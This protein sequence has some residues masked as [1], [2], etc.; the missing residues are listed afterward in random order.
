MRIKL[1]QLFYL[2][3]NERNIA[4]LFVITRVYRIYTADCTCWFIEMC[5]Y[6]SEL[7]SIIERNFASRDNELVRSRTGIKIMLIDPLTKR[8]GDENSLEFTVR[9]SVWRFLFS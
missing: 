4:Y 7:W 6:E 2:V 1:A 3:K 9:H 8:A 5:K